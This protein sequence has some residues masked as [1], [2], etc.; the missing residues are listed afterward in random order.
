MGRL[1]I[2]VIYWNNCEKRYCSII[3]K[4]C[5]TLFRDDLQVEDNIII[6]IERLKTEDLRSSESRDHYHEDGNLVPS[7]RY[8]FRFEAVSRL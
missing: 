7:P 1:T 4:Q 3:H 8:G 6:Y 5:K 2:A